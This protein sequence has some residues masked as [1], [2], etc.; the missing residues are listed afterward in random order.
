MSANLNPELQ[1]IK[2]TKEALSTALIAICIASS[3]RTK[4]RI[5]C[6][7]DGIRECDINSIKIL[8]RKQP[9]LTL[10]WKG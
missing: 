10:L 6:D 7:F 1:E 8:Q 2:D 4:E 9:K 5:P 3:R